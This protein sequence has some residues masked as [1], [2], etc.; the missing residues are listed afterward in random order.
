MAEDEINALT[1]QIIGCAFTVGNELGCGFLE[2]IYE[3]ALLHELHACGL[4]VQQQHPLKV[5]YK[6]Q[7]VGH[8]TADLLV[9]GQVLLELK[10]VQALDNVHLAQCL[11]YLKATGLSLCLLLNFGTPRV[12]VKRV[13]N[14]SD[15]EKAARQSAH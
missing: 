4:R 9:Q 11:N 10:A 6:D 3:N 1:Q 12:E 8:Y 2:N 14:Y 13:T 15:G 7:V 5:Y